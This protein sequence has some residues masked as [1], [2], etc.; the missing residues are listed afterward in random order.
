MQFFSKKGFSR[1]TTASGKTDWKRLEDDYKAHL[2]SIRHRL[3]PAWQ[4]SVEEDFHDE[5]ILSVHHSSKSEFIMVLGSATL[6]FTGVRFIW[7]PRSVV[8]DCWLYW[9]S[10][11]QMRAESI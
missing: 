11:W 10:I 5:K 4:Q 2:D 8:D 7:V 9:K 6:R 1:Y 3:S